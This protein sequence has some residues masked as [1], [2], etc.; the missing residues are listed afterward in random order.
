MVKKISF[1]LI[2]LSLTSAT[3]INAQQAS[4]HEKRIFQAKDGKLYINKDLP[5]YVRIASSPDEDAESWLLES[6]KT[7]E[8]ANPMYLDV[9]GW[10]SLRSPSAVDTATKEAVVPVQDIVFDMYA[11]GRAPATN[12]KYG[13]SEFFENDGTTFFGDDIDLKFDATDQMSGVEDVYYAINGNDF[14][15]ASQHPLDITEEGEYKLKFY[16]VDNVGNVEEPQ[17]FRFTIDQTPPATEHNVDNLKNDKVLSPDA[18]ITLAGDDN[19]SG[20]A[21][22]Y[23]AVD[24]EDFQ[25]Y[26]NPIPVSVLKKTKGRITYYAVDNTGNKEEPNY[27]GTMASADKKSE[28][29]EGEDFDYYI[30]REPPKPEFTFEGD[31][32]EGDRDYISERT[33]IV[34]KATDDKSGVQKILYSYNGFITQEEYDDPFNPEGN[35]PVEL[36]YTAVDN[37]DNRA[38]E[39]SREFYIDRNAPKS[40]LSFDGS[41]FKNRDTTF[42]SGQTK[43][44]LNAS[45]TESG[46]KNIQFRLNDQEEKAFDQPFVPEKSGPNSIEWKATDN[47]N[48]KEE[49]NEQLFVVDQ[50]APS[51]HHHFS[52]EPIGEKVVRDEKYVIYPSNTKLY[53]GATDDVTGEESLKYTINDGK[54]AKTIPVSGFEP[55]NYEIVIEAEDAL[56]NK[57]QKTIRFAIEK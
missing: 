11:D 56:N 50:E 7:G 41:V 35:S 15:P 9:E 37:V 47:V 25:K 22:I 32:Y 6:E 42:I 31:H 51:V 34:L 20:V 53:I 46:V 10:N 16:A 27:I 3:T 14:Q 28:N 39:K 12:L 17:S 30:D 5:I 21:G 52:V 33:Q 18:T 54:T 4:E 23:Y 2:V 19:L 44:A 43:I 8:Y 29:E 45:D 49:K 36:L 48:N 13:T 55:G 1:G 40:E 24:D 57:T 26:E 38:P